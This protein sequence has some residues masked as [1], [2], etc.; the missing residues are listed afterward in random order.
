[1]WVH[2]AGRNGQARGISKREDPLDWVLRLRT[3]G[4]QQ[5]GAY[6]TLDF[7]KLRGRP[8]PAPWSI[9]ISDNRQKGVLEW[10]IRSG[11]A[12]I[13]DRMDDKLA[14]STSRVRL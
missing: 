1:V 4:N 7:R 9:L 14:L 13:E 10:A 8:E 11:V 3:A 5:Q 6:F 12:A 2:H